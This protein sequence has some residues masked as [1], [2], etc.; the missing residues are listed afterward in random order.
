MADS[1]LQRVVLPLGRGRR[2][3]YYR[4][5]RAGACLPQGRCGIVLPRAAVFRTDAFFN[6]FY[7]CYWRKYT[8]LQRLALRLHVQ[9]EGV[10]RLYRCTSQREKRLLHEVAFSGAERELHIA[11][12]APSHEGL[13]FFEIEAN[14]ARLRI[15]RAEWIACDTEARPVRLAVGVCTFNRASQL[16]RNLKRLFRDRNSLKSLE[17]AYI[18]DQGSELVR[19]HPTYATL[20]AAVGERLQVIE[21]DN[22]GGAGGFTRCLLEA[23]EEGH[24]THVLLMDDDIVLEPESVARAA[25]FLSLARGDVGVGGHMLDRY[26]PLELVESGSRYLPKTLRIDEPRR[27]RVDRPDGLMPFLEPEP[28]HYSGWWFFA[29]PLAALE[30]S[31]LPLPLFLRG[32]DVEFGCRLLHRGVP[33]VALPGVAVWHEPFES[34]GRSWQPF[35]ELRNLLIVGALHFPHIGARTAARQFFSRLL[36]EL[37]AYDYYE[38]WLLCEAAAAYLRGPMALG[39]PD[40]LGHQRLAD[41]QAKLTPKPVP[42]DLASPREDE[43]RCQMIPST[44]RWRRWRLVLRNL[45]RASPSEE[46]G[47]QRTLRGGGEQWYDVADVDVVT[48]DESHRSECVVLRRSRSRFVRL[49]LRGVWFAIRLLI[50]HR[51]IARKWRAATPTLT[52]Q[53]FWKKY[54]NMPQNS[55]VRS[56]ANALPCASRRIERQTVA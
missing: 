25:A 23:K 1:I 29:F 24:A 44:L 10:V 36:D 38:S 54:L 7:E 53:A 26:R 13:L 42:R 47:P 18:V 16:L 27:R 32:D 33:T 17:R 37:L 2:R 49:M 50:C 43:P 6:A 51:R 22:R 48:V 20:S 56:G 9:G 14:S 5:N 15:H 40:L 3:L 55:L 21:Q 34:K 39:K 46:A 12:A 35:Y 41:M 45:L 4:E 19:D 52:S 11:I 31:G 28:R 30:R 8:S